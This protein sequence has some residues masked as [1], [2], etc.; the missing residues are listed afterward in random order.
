VPLAASRPA[1]LGAVAGSVDSVERDR[2]SGWAWYHLT[3]DE[4][5]D[6]EILVDDVAVLKVRADQPRAD[7]AAAGAGQGRHGFLV[8]D[9]EEF[10]PPGTHV[11]RVR[12]ALDSLDLPGCPVR[13]TVPDMPLTDDNMNIDVP[14]G[15]IDSIDHTHIQ[16]WAWDP[17]SP[18]EPVEVEVLVDGT[19]VLA[20]RADL[21]RPDLAEAG[22][23]TG[24]H[25]FIVL[26]LSSFLSEGTHAVRLRRAGDHRD[27][28]GSPTGVSRGD[29]DARAPLSPEDALAVETAAREEEAAPVEPPVRPRI[30]P[31]RE[32]ADTRAAGLIGW[33]DRLSF[34]QI[35]GWVWDPAHP[36]EPVNIEILDGD[37]VVLK[38]PADQ[39]RADLLEGGKGDGRHGFTVPNVGGILPLSRHRVRVRRASDGWDLPG[40]PA[41]ITRAAPD[42]TAMAFTREMVFTAIE[43]AA[44]PE[45]LTEPLGH[46]LMLLNDMV[47][48]QEGLARMRE[49]P[50][51]PP[52]EAAEALHVSGRTRE[53]VAQMRYAYAP[54]YFEPTDDP[55]VS[56]IIPVHN[57]FRYTYDCLKSMLAALPTRTFEII[58]IDDFSD[59]ETLFA[60]LVFSGGVRIRR[61]AKNLGFVGTCNAGAALARGKYLLFLNNDTLVKPGWLDELV[62]TFEQ[63][64]NVGI[65]GSKLLFA[66]GKLQEA[67]GI[68]WRLGDGW[69][70]GRGR[71]PNEPA[72]SYLRDADW[73]SGAALMIPR[74]LFRELNGFDEY[75]APAYY[76]DTDIAFRVRAMGKRVVV[77][78]ASVITHLEGVSAGT[79]TAGTG[80]KRFQVINHA[81]FYRRWKDTLITHRLNGQ[82]P[83]L[84]AERQVRRRAYFIDDSVP[85]PDQDAGSNAAV[86]HM[87]CLMA[88]GYKV[89]FLPADNM[90]AIEPY[91]GRLQKL[92]IECLHHPYFWSVEEVFRKAAVKPDLVYLHRHSNASKYATMVRRYFPRCRVIYSVAD[93]HFLRMERQATVEPA[94]MSKAKVAVQRRDELGVMANVDSIIVHSSVEAALLREVDGG[95]DVRVVPWTVRP[96]ATA[97]PFADRAGAAFVGGFH[98]P[99]NVD[100]VRFLVHDVA[101]LLRARVPE[102][103]VWL[104]GSN[105]PNEIMN[106][107]VPGVKPLGFVPELADILHRLRCTVVPLRYGAGIKGKVLES[108][109]HGLP[110]VMSEVAAEG[111]EL[112]EDLAWLVARSPEAFAEKT[113]RVHADE[114]FNRALAES[115]LAYIERRHSAAAVTEALRARQEIAESH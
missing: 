85:T 83:E 32:Q 105:M 60:A 43:G 55:E 46:L 57:Q 103:T 42:E 70:W 99:P 80:M 31:R 98:H 38:I 114:A 100:A 86:E 26:N 2:L 14:I 40:S 23:G 67:G 36:N 50:N 6:V 44:R 51:I 13:I 104:V 78:P 71:D 77:Q 8:R 66:D 20:M 21:L 81:K 90:A 97:R 49:T 47:N 54:L 79:D 35:N 7:L 59:D 89:T 64:P 52:A 63:V 9:F 91:T 106:M 11:V 17:A 84:E 30:D 16:G 113:A 33:V 112:P 48:A 58:I 61:N 56:V 15:G 24:K 107:Q 62:E 53:L 18:D 101:P 73:V 76:E 93:L 5:I 110:C 12:R 94:A 69:N 68:I 28:P 109:A 115:G 1:R 87:R 39:F 82:Q 74:D 27:L 4:A 72:F 96:R 92:G 95:L 25:G 10:L 41:W 45:D 65:A 37:T 3:P 88:L 34:E 111:L 75:Y 108:F 29:L 102:C 19:H 22:R